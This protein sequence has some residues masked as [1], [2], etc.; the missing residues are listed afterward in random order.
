MWWERMRNR[1]RTS[2]NKQER[3]PRS[4]PR[5]RNDRAWLTGDAP[6]DE[7]AAEDDRADGDAARVA[8]DRR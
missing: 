6:V 4:L 5:T 7:D 1:S 8:S 2:E 3:I